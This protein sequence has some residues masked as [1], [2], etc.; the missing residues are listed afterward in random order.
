MVTVS[1]VDHIRLLVVE[2]CQTFCILGCSRFFPSCDKCIQ[3]FVDSGLLRRSIL[4]CLGVRLLR[5]SGL[6][7]PDPMRLIIAS[8]NNSI[9]R[10]G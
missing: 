3:L 7:T 1:V 6:G 8:A 4:A 5:E 2:N 10:Q 9:F